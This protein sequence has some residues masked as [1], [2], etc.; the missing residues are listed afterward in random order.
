MPIARKQNSFRSTFYGSYVL[1]WSYGKNL[2][3]FTL[4]VL[5]YY[6]QEWTWAK[7]FYSL[8]DQVAA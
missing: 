8:I 1:I 7:V 5:Y 4:T 2:N 3:L 6:K